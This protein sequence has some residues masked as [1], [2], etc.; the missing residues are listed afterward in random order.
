[1]S[2]FWSNYVNMRDREKKEGIKEDTQQK[3]RDRQQE[4]PWKQTQRTNRSIYISLHLNL[5]HLTWDLLC[6]A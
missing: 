1:M 2:F 6:D 3:R 4:R 5:S